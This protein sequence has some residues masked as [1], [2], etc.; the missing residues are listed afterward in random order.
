MLNM[1][2]VIVAAYK[3]NNTGTNAQVAKLAEVR[4]SKIANHSVSS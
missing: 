4:V 2:V 1:Q 3:L